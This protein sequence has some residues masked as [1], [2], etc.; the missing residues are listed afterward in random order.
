MKRR[1]FIVAGRSHGRQNGDRAVPDITASSKK[2]SVFY[3]APGAT[4]GDLRREAPAG[5]GRQYAHEVHRGTAA[6]A[7]AA[8]SRVTI[9]AGS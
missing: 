3:G 2:A 1:V 7:C 5:L 8:C 6:V 4:A 9:I